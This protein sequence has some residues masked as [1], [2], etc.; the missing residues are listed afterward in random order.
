MVTERQIMILKIIAGGVIVF[1]AVWAWKI[2]I[3]IKQQKRKERDEAP[4][5]RW[6][7]EVHQRPSQ[8]EKLRQAKEENISVHFESEKKVKTLLS[9]GY[10]GKIIGTTGNVYLVTLK[11]C[12]C[13]DFKRRQK[14]CKHMYF[15]AAQTMRCN[16]S[17]VNGKYELEKLN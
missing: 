12:T 8:K 7:D 1:L 3:Y 15:L 10:S 6:T 4:F 5:R 16:I 17:E 2:R 11:N 14:P 9:N 13:Q